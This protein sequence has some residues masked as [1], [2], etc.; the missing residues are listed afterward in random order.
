VVAKP[1]RRKLRWRSPLRHSPIHR[2]TTD[3]E[4]RRVS[5]AVLCIPALKDGFSAPDK[6]L[7]T[8]DPFA[9]Q[10]E[11]S[12]LKRNTVARGHAASFFV[13]FWLLLAC[14]RRD[15]SVRRG[16]RLLPTSGRGWAAT[17]P[18]LPIA[19]SSNVVRRGS[20]AHWGHLPRQTTLEAGIHP[21]PGS[22]ITAIFGFSGVL[23]SM[24][25]E[26]KTTSMTFGSSIPPRT[27][28]RGG[29]EAVRSRVL[30]PRSLSR[31]FAVQLGFTARRER[32]RREI[33]PAAA[34]ALPFGLTTAATSGSLAVLAWPQPTPPDS[35][36][37]SGCS[38]LRRRNGRGWEEITRSFNSA[39]I[40]PSRNPSV[41]TDS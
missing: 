39:A 23:D 31:S 32:L 6:Y 17:T 3:A 37:I 11:H 4:L 16:R 34:T 21:Q 5:L 13:F 22:T 33:F 27:C 38:I 2:T 10:F 35:S 7:P 29:V 15:D 20:T 8:I 25:M 12:S 24:R 30:A 9:I 14:V 1:L 18:F 19:H 40:H 36:V 41:P 28:G 26:T